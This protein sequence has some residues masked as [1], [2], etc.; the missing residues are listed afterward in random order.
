[1]PGISKAPGSKHA[2]LMSKF[3]VRHINHDGQNQSL[4]WQNQIQ[5]HEY[6]SVHILLQA[7]LKIVTGCMG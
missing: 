1:M 4:T 2:G 5:E 7:L 6:T 3:P